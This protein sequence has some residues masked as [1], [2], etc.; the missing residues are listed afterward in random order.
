[1]NCTSHTMY[2]I[3]KLLAYIV[4][5]SMVKNVVCRYFKFARLFATQKHLEKF[6]KPQKF[7]CEFSKKSYIHFLKSMS[8]NMFQ[9]RNF[10]KNVFRIF[11][12]NAK[13]GFLKIYVMNG[14][15]KQCFWPYHSNLYTISFQK[16]YILCG[17]Q[18][19]ELKS[20]R[21]Q[22]CVLCMW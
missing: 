22:L 12:I 1:M 6:F 18:F 10:E 19:M 21:R 16:M 14:T 17:V 9:E 15:D 13:N 7:L 2:I 3:W 20:S 5:D 11:C 8:A 4:S